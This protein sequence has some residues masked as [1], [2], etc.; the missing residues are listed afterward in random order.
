MTGTRT[1]YLIGSAAPPVMQ[2][3]VAC[4]SAIELGWDPCVVLT[5]TAADWVDVDRLAEVSG[6]PVR[7]RPRLPDESDPLPTADAVLAAPLTFNT[8]NKWAAGISDTLALG[9]LNEFLVGGPPIIAVP[10][11]KG[12]LRAHPAFPLSTRLLAAAGVVFNDDVPV[13]GDDGL[14]AVDWPRLIIA[15][16]DNISGLA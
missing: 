6:K 12:S 16:T 10:C 11:V 3:D 15:L 1:L 14:A 5:P 7:I 9:L 13:T 8:I 2:L 4:L